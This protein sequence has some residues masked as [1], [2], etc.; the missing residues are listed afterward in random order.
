MKNN[1]YTIIEALRELESLNDYDPPYSAEQIKKNYGEDTYN[2]LK[3]DPAHKWRME[4]GIELIHKEPSLEE[5][6]RI[7]SNWLLMTDEM[8]KESDEKSMELFGV[9]NVE[10]YNQLKKEYKQ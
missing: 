7:Y 2:K 5:L 4:T 3:N 10:H 1:N 9:K 6:N 8:K